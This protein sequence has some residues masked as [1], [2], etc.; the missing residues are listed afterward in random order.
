[1]KI[2]IT[3]VVTFVVTMAMATGIWLWVRA[4]R[5]AA[6]PTL[7]CVQKPERGD[8]TEVVSA[9]AEVEPKT[10]VDI[11]A[12][13]SA[14]TE[15]LPYEEGDRVTKGD[16]D[17]EPPIEP[18]VLVQLDATD[19][20]AALRSVEALRAARA[21]HIEVEKAR[22]A[23]QRAQIEGLGASL[24]E[25][26]RN[27]GRQKEL[28]E[29]GDVSQA[30]FDLAQC[31]AQELEAQLSSAM[32]SLKASETNLVVL[33]HNLE[34]ADAEIERARDRLTYTTIT[35]PI[36]GVVTKVVAEVGE[37]VIPGTMNNPGTVIMQVADLSRMLL[38][39]Q[40]DETDI[41]RVEV[42]QRATAKIHANP[43]EEFEGVVDSIALTHDFGWGGVK[44]YKT[45]ILLKLEGRRVYSGST[46]DVD[47]ETR[48]HKDVL[49]VPS[50]A[51][52]E[53][54]VDELPRGVRENNPNVDKSK[55]YATVVYCFADGEAVVAPVKIGPSDETHTL[56]HSGIAED[57]L[58]ITGPYKVLEGIKHQQ[59]VKEEPE[60]E[61]AESGGEEEAPEQAGE[62]PDKDRDK[63]D[64]E[65][66]HDPHRRAGP[67]AGSG[68]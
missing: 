63:D 62:K 1:M 4:K 20:D 60:E 14:R 13:V 7:V 3:C 35:S 31:R 21:A 58:I 40:V 11:S 66:R 24:L 6:D 38:V 19:L 23:G 29:S 59:K 49:R 22:I 39:A 30:T 34:A 53:R 8:L 52:L 32:H 2:V 44:Y 46:A 50:Q 12:R 47:I 37:T 41:G 15:A 43:D 28:H 18:S 48:Y 65:D 68:T 17:A 36:D 33:R 16:P 51:V 26:Q 10:S 67:D 5:E 25:A 27:L 45:E 54:L 56:I 42:G 57:D 55:T 64:G 9:R 61:E